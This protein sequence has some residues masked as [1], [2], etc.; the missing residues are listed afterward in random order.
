[1]GVKGLLPCLQSITRSVSLERYRGLTVAVDAMSWLHKGV[2]ACD[3]KS[4]AKIQRGDES[5]KATSAELKCINYTTRKSE[6]LKVKFGIEVILVIDGDSLPSKKEENAQ[7]REER[8]KAFEKAVAAEKA[9]DSRA[10]RRFYAQSCSVTHK[11]RYELI[12]ACKQLNIAF[13]V[14]PYEADAQ[15]ARL[16][17]VGIVDL[18]ITEDSDILVYGCPRAC[19]KVDFDTDQGQEIQL[20]RDL[21]E[22][23]TLSFRN[24]THDMFVFMSII[25]GCDYCKGVP[26]IGIKL[27]HKLVRV[28]RT[29]SKIF[30]A[31]RAAGRMPPD[32]EEKFWI[33]FRTFR[34]QRVY[35]PVKQQIETLWPIAGSN[36]D[37]GS[38][39]V[40]PFLGEHVEPGI[41]NGIANGTLHPSKKIAWDEAL[42]SEH[43]N[44]KMRTQS[45]RSC[46]SNDAQNRRDATSAKSNVWHTLVYGSKDDDGRGH[47]ATNNAKENQIGNSTQSTK[48]DMF[49]FFPQSKNHA[50][51]A[52]KGGDKS[53]GNSARPPLQDIYVGNDS[54]SQSQSSNLES[55]KVQP[56]C[57]KDVPIH[58]HEYASRLVGKSFKPITRKRKKQE[59]DGSK[60]SKYVQKIWE[61]CAKVQERT[62]QDGTPEED[63]GISDKQSGVSR[64]K[65]E[66]SKANHGCA[67]QE[68]DYFRISMGETYQTSEYEHIMD[69]TFAQQ[70]RHNED[71]RKDIIHQ[72]FNSVEHVKEDAQAHYD[73]HQFS[74]QYTTDQNWYPEDFSSGVTTSCEDG[75]RVGTEHCDHNSMIQPYLQPCV[76]DSCSI[77]YEESA[78]DNCHLFTEVQNFTHRSF[79]GDTGGEERGVFQQL[80]TTMKKKRDHS[81]CRSY[82]IKKTD[83]EQPA[84]GQVGFQYFSGDQ[85]FNGGSSG[86]ANVVVF[87][88]ANYQTGDQDE[89]SREEQEVFQQLRTTMKKKRDYRSCRSYLDTRD[90]EQPIGDHANFPSFPCDGEFYGEMISDEANATVFEELRHF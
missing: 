88:E 80:R 16:A 75:D 78:S 22:N 89:A 33:A 30:S 42:T 46:T 55:T 8:D 9:R 17:H 86:D 29:P 81:S 23:D 61:K 38:N 74:H 10:A 27:A 48:R 34:H 26:G 44:G 19:F 79:G 52:A 24:W 68:S 56:A 59:N 72:A 50:T 28:H 87:G 13:L 6:T 14:A 47:Q 77:A 1:M 12:K 67:P 73:D 36:H 71:P 25:S 54:T 53:N 18:V 43:D 32:F 85:E 11:M 64:F 66:S 76:F 35:C 84:I 21:G 62:R 69:Q 70:Y 31:L 51:E 90:T 4:L 5:E 40:W 83:E 39:E 57:R 65:K 63:K 58:F 37:A 7:R 41:A 49:S 82:T 45:E 20:M 3:V 15:M 60:S 2:F